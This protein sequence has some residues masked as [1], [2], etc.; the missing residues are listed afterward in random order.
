[1]PPLRLLQN[2]ESS[3]SE[4]M[5][6]FFSLATMIE[7]GAVAAD[8]ADKDS[9]VNVSPEQWAR[10]CDILKDMAAKV[11]DDLDELEKNI[12]ALVLLLKK[13]GTQ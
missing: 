4:A 13:E 1:M 5:Y 3:A 12:N 6:S 10:L 2:V 7:F 11:A 8:S 9:H